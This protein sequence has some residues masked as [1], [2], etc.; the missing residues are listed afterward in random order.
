MAIDRAQLDQ[1]FEQLGQALT[2]PTTLCIF[3]SAPGILLGQPARQTQDVDVW[4]LASTY[5]AGD[6]SR[7][8]KAAGVLY[9]PTGEIDP[10]TIYLRIS[11][12]GIVAL[13]PSFETELL[14]TYGRLTVVMPAP[15]VLTA[16]KL[17]RANE[18]DLGDITWWVTQRRLEVMH[19]EHVIRQIP[20][21][22]HQETA[23]ENLVFVRLIAGNG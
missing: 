9:N 22:R 6:L 13:P 23:R 12:P 16:A 17:V 7:A 4:H 15:A 10:E 2:Q 3:G 18:N 20:D 11:R 19:L 5:D 8:C 21:R 14:G 1:M